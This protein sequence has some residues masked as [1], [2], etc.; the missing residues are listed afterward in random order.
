MSGMDDDANAEL[1][2]GSKT[3]IAEL[4]AALAERDAMLRLAAEERFGA[5]DANDQYFNS[6]DWI[7]GLRQRVK[8][9]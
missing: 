2:T 1:E 7:A 9:T 6:A 4:E 5:A 3:R 8:T